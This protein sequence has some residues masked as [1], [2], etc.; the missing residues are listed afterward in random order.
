[1]APCI[2]DSLLRCAA[3][4]LAVLSCGEALRPEHIQRTALGPASAVPETQ[5]PPPDDSDPVHLF[6]Q[7]GQSECVG[8]ASA[9]LLEQDDTPEFAPFKGVPDNIWMAS[10]EGEKDDNFYITKL[11]PDVTKKGNFG[12][13]IGFSRRYHEVT[14]ARV[15]IIK[16][17]L[18]GS[19]VRH[20]WNPDDVGNTWD[21]D[22]DDNTS[23]WLFE[24]GNVSWAKQSL[25]K[26]HVY[27]VRRTIEALRDAN[28]KF[29]WKGIIWI[30]GSADRQS[31]VEVFGSDTA[32]LWNA[33]RERVVGNTTLPIIDKGGDQQHTLRSGKALAAQL[34]TGCNVASV[35]AGSGAEDPESTCVIGPTNPCPEST[36][37]NVN[38]YNFFGWDPKVPEDLKPKGANARQFP[39]FK[40]Y[41]NDLHSEYGGML[42][43]G[44]SMA[45]AFIQ[46]FTSF[47]LTERMERTDPVLKFPFPE[48]SDGQSPSPDTFCWID[49]RAAPGECMP[50]AR[51]LS[52]P[53]E[54]SA[55]MASMPLIILVIIGHA[56][57][58]MFAG[59]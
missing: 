35:E 39:W 7:G 56:C 22:A 5:L 48:C 44:V 26:N 12:V 43:Q 17:C 40:D 49:E 59:C 46:Q 1:M 11:A 23:A 54:S 58:G 32:R 27:V 4:G 55:Q 3:M 45:N 9:S 57:L 33:I 28:V 31:T 18:G 37:I 14:G 20:Q 47:Q 41:P 16:Y 6:W 29:V 42:L 21:Y 30:Q 2:A 19:N 34:V 53:D 25:F 51:M 50:P 13:E 36:F 38:Y 52:A 10:V 8:K 24:N 15:L